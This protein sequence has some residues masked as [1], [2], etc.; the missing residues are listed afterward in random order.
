[1]LIYKTVSCLLFPFFMDGPVNLNSALKCFYFLFVNRIFQNN[2]SRR[3]Y[4]LNMYI[5]F[6]LDFQVSQLSSQIFWKKVF[7]VNAFL[8]F[9]ARC[10]NLSANK[11]YQPILWLLLFLC[12]TINRFQCYQSLLLGNF[13]LFH[14]FC[15]IQA[16][17]RDR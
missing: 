4:F 16:A 7:K 11:E 17:A 3:K 8:K 13:Y 1:M 9:L 14:F 2:H 5:V 12:S 15:F 10:P 6:P